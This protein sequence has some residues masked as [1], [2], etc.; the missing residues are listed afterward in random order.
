MAVVDDAASLFRAA[1]GGATLALL[2]KLTVE[3]ANQCK[4]EEARAKLQVGVLSAPDCHSLCSALSADA[5]Q[6]ARPKLMTPN[7][8][9]TTYHQERTFS[10]M[11]MQDASW[12]MLGDCQAQAFSHCLRGC[13]HMSGLAV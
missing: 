8:W 3:A 6:G 10:R 11:A 7:A 9:E 5:V 4:M 2:A 13:S 12:K 1:D